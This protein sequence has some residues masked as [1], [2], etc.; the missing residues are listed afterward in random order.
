MT[1]H[2]PHSRNSV[3]H[4]RSLCRLLL[5]LPLLPVLLLALTSCDEPVEPG[6]PPPHVQQ[7]TTSH[8]IEWTVYRFGPGIPSSSL[9]DIIAFSD[10]NVWAVGGVYPDTPDTGA[11]GKKPYTVLH[12]NGREWTKFK[13]PM[14]SCLTFKP[15]Y[16][17]YY[18]I[19]GEPG[20]LWL[21]GSS[22]SGARSD[23]R[24]FWI[25]CFKSDSSSEWGVPSEKI[26]YAS[27]DEVYFAGTNYGIGEISQF[28]DDRFTSIAKFPDAPV[29]SLAGDGKGNLWAG[30]YDYNTG[31][32]SFVW[33]TPDGTVRDLRKNELIDGKW[34][35]EGVTSLWVSRDSLYAYFAGY[36]YIQAL[37][38]PS[39]YRYLSA[40]NVDP[41]QGWKTCITGTGNNDVFIAGHFLSVIHYNGKSLRS[42]PELSKMFSGGVFHGISVTSDY[43]FVC[44]TTNETRA[45]IA[46]GRRI[47]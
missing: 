17:P 18:S 46:V 24:S 36:L 8:E 12:W 35:F 34:D 10:T 32:G 19:A 20:N 26:Y 29:T 30:G 7:D 31:K 5:A 43:V 23:E 38:D 28:R 37:Y 22:G 39:H 16:S 4:G 14:A 3:R 1:A 27:K 45:I 15:L 42:Y 9:R 13:V 21:S 44:G 25:E 6:P 40:T 11:L 2:V 47:K 41:P 33:R